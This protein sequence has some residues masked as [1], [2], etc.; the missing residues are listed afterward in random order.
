MQTKPEAAEAA[1]AP[2][3]HGKP[4]DEMTPFEAASYFFHQSAERLGLDDQM[5]EVLASSY[6]EL[7]VQVPVR[8]D[9]GSVTVYRGYRIQHNGARG[10]YK[11]GI[12]YPL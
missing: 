2:K 7:A 10:P 5:R 6:R 8:M 9:D 4:T 11:G 12:R 3:A 1:A